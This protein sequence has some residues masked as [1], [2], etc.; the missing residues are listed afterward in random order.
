[1][2]RLFGEGGGRFAGNGGSHS[3]CLL[4]PSPLL[5]SEGILWLT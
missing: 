4:P 1:M 2:N 3:R 5:Y